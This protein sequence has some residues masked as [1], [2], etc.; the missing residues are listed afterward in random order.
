VFVDKKPLDNFSD[1][2]NLSD[3]SSQIAQEL[4]SKRI[5]NDAHVYILIEL[6]HIVKTIHNCYLRSQYYLNL[7]ALLR[8]AFKFIKK[9]LNNNQCLNVDQRYDDTLD[10]DAPLS[11]SDED[12]SDD[13]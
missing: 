10:E 13:E 2:D 7:R 12:D 9:L 5:E 11:S 4:R 3:T 6:L 8:M 1:V